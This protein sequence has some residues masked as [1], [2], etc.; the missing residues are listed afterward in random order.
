MIFILA[1][2]GRQS[3][4]AGLTYHNK[5]NSNKRT[6][7]R[8]Q[9]QEN[10]NKRTATREQQQENSNKRTATREQLIKIRRNPPELFSNYPPVLALYTAMAY[11][12]TTDVSKKKILWTILLNA[13]I[14]IAEFIGGLVTGYLALLADA[15]HNLSDVAA[16]LLA[17]LG[18]KGSQLPATKKSTYGYKRIE[19]MTAFISAVALVVIG[20]FIIHEAW[21]RYLHPQ[22][23]SDP[24]LFLSIATIG[25]F[26]N[27]FS[28][29]ILHSEKGKSLN[30]KS[31]FIHMYYDML[32]SI[33]VIIGGIIIIT[34]GLVI[35]DP[36]LS[37]II[38]LM[39]FKSSYMV[40]RDA[41]L[42]FLEAVP[43]TVNFD[44]VYD[45]ILRI[46]PVTDVHDLHIWSLSSNEIALSCH[47]CLEE[48]DF[49]SGPDTIVNINAMLRKQFNIGHGTIQLEKADC[50]RSD[51]L[52]R[53]TEPRW[54]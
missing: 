33:A 34:T 22:A 50:S 16:L 38:A 40:I 45:A 11:V 2:I 4:A 21:Q 37:A 53:H 23:L 25:L 9:Q 1:N 48:R 5:E 30:M 24:W 32:S 6:A 35:I 49:Q 18:A 20:V 3:A 12:H 39:L 47:I 41:T 7:T 27:L 14:T 36:I 17:L 51:L 19:V 26:G 28:V 52:C 44:D 10:S 46:S 31:A 15:V 29:R 8:E 42:I 43:A 54:E 13:G